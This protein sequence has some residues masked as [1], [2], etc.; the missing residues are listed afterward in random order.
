[1]RTATRAWFPYVLVALSSA[2]VGC[3]TAANNG[4]GDSGG[5]GTTVPFS[6]EAGKVDAEAG[7]GGVVIVGSGMDSGLP[8]VTVTSD[9]GGGGTPGDATTT[10]NPDTG[11]TT[12]SDAATADV[13]T[14]I[15]DAAS[16]VD[17]PI[18]THPD[19]AQN[20]GDA[21]SCGFT[22]GVAA[23]DSCL[24]NS[25]CASETKCANSS[26]CT[27]CVTAKTPAASCSSNADYKAFIACASG[28]CNTAC[29]GTTDGGTPTGGDAGGATGGGTPTTCAQ[30]DTTVGC[31]GANGDN[32]YCASATS[33]TVSKT[34]CAT[35]KVCGWS[36]SKMYYECVSGTAEADP[37]GTYPIACK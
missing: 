37:S 5:G 4:S 31:C 15:P 10:S 32:Y 6:S 17:A 20:T 12:G 25:C 7:G 24:T 22:T 19:A 9:G 27:T 14:T 33:T 1:M 2:A 16:V 8:S 13:G 35:G 11:T 28:D 21:G 29:G 18:T 26:A 34:A 3:A 23:C 36:A 30:A